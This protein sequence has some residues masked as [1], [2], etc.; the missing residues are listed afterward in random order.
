MR[1]P[2]TPTPFQQIEELYG[3]YAPSLYRRACW[4]TGEP[5]ESL[6]ITQA[7]FLSFMLMTWRGDAS[8]SVILY[9]IATH[10]AV[11]RLRRRAR[12]MGNRGA[13][14]YGWRC[15]ADLW[16]RARGT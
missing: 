8:P 3:L 5:E 12:W 16:G 14:A 6:D 4:S 9:A 10:K 1:M 2:G 7:T 13:D 11:D 15:A